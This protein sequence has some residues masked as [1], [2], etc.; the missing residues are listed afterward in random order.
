MQTR[1]QRAY[2]REAPAHISGDFVSA[3]L[4]KE[5]KQKHKCRSIRLRVGDKVKI[6]R[7]SFRNKT[8]K[9]DRINVKAQ[10]IY[11]TGIELTKR[12][13]SKAMCPIHPSNILIQEPDLS[14]KRRIGGAKQ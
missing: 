12:D 7:G 1:K 3:H 2:V 14:D 6:M 10:K 8:G 4:S 9:V 5:L 11:I 13:G